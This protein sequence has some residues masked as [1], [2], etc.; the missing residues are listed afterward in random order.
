M[1]R[2]I[3]IA[4]GKGG[5]GK[6]T[7]ALNLGMSLLNF[8]REVI[9]VDANFHAPNVG[10]YLG[11]SMNPVT[12]NDVL[13][14]NRHITEAVYSHASGLKI[15]PMHISL[16][17]IKKASHGRLREA[18]EGLNN[19]CEAIL[20]DTPAGINTET[21]EILRACHD[22]ILVTT[23]DVVAAT[24]ALKTKK[25][26]ESQGANVLGVVVNRARGDAL[27]MSVTNIEQ[28]LGLPVLEVIPEDESVRHSLHMRHPVSYSHPHSK[29]S[30]Q[31][32]KLAG[33]LIGERYVE[34]LEKQE[35]HGL[36][37]KILK[38]LGFK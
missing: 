37:T 18:L 28:M 27:E 26:A 36:F 35:K 17:E 15:V 8:G 12:L 22:V 16:G 14:G 9:V 6:T 21:E 19:R 33:R 5:T 38:A 24:E 32:R 29:A 7:V 11:S 23:P 34:N 1:T 20:V 2:F 10:L 13:A 31:F 25:L 3:A 4:S 30:V